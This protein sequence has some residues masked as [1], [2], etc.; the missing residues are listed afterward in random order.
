MRREKNNDYDGIYRNPQRVPQRR[1][2]ETARATATDR[3]REGEREREGEGEGER[4][5]VAKK[6]KNQILSYSY[7]K[8]EFTNRCVTNE[9]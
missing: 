1:E 4:K 9:Y 7:D 2:K 3:R 6:T 5:E 8:R